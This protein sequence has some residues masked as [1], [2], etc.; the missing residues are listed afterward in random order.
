[1]LLVVGVRNLLA[2]RGLRQESRLEAKAPL[3]TRNQKMNVQL[4]RAQ[5]ALVTQDLPQFG[6]VQV[7]KALLVLRLHHRGLALL[8]R[9]LALLYRGLA[10][11]YRGLALLYRGLVLLA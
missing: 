8:Y 6:D 3:E 10:L 2:A 7:V 9:G 4:M 1:M 5:D 11:L